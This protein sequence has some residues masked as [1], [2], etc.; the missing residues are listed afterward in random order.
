MTGRVEGK[1]ALVSGAGTRGAGIGNGR[2]I[3]MALAREGAKV[4]LLDSVAAAAQETADAIADTERTLVLEGDA[5][6][7]D[8]CSSAVR[9]V[10]QRWGRIDILVNV[11]GLA[12]Y[13]ADGTV[14][15][16]D[17]DRWD[18]MMR[19]N[20]KSMVVTARCVVPRMREGGS[21]SIV[22]LSS[23][24]GLVGIGGGVAYPTSKAAIVGLT[25][26]MAAHHGPEGIRVNCV[27]PGMIR[28]PRVARLY[29]P[30]G[31]AAAW[32]ESTALPQIEADVSMDFQSYCG[33]YTYEEGVVTHH[34]EVGLRPSDVGSRKSRTVEMRGADLI[35]SSESPPMAQRPYTA[36]LVWRRVQ[37]AT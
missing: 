11:V 30:G 27:A 36:R 16:V 13:E 35:L 5:T 19:V 25:R 21:G 34:V 7:V 37:P 23:I 24:G 1:V 10:W 29:E 8:Q 20:V 12:G 6:D 3:A 28:T 4:G 22:N 31:S 14:V 26:A 32:R 2:A 9:R 17:L 33:R 18:R 15:D